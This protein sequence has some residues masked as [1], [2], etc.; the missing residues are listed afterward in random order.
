MGLVDRLRKEP[1]FFFIEHAIGHIGIKNIQVFIQN[2]GRRAG[3]LEMRVCLLLEAEEGFPLL[4]GQL[5]RPNVF[6]KYF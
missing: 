1:N 5:E 2:K 6:S 4:I 3:Q